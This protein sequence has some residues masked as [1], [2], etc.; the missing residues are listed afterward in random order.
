MTVSASIGV[1]GSCRL[2]DETDGTEIVWASVERWARDWFTEWRGNEYGTARDFISA[3]CDHAVAGVVDALVVLAE[4]AGG[5]EK[6]LGWVGAGPLE[7]LVSHSGNGLKMLG[8]VDRAARQ[9]V[10]FR[11]ALSNTWLGGDV[12][13]TVRKRLAVLGARLLV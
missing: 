2:I 13:E 12:P 4:I 3:A 1:D 8:Q 11:Q 9:N 10:S 6:L 7:D 5:E